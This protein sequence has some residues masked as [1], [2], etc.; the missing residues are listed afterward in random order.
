MRL[1]DC[2]SGADGSPFGAG[3]DVLGHCRPHCTFGAC[4]VEDLNSSKYYLGERYPCRLHGE[5]A[6]F[7]SESG[8]AY[9]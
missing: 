3:A 5:A 7:D 2:L 1:R 6:Y 9:Q 8:T 4:Y